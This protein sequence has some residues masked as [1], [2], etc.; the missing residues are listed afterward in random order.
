MYPV[1]IG[2]ALLA[3]VVVKLPRA[4]VLAPCDTSSA[5]SAVENLLHSLAFRQRR[6]TIAGGF[7]LGQE[8]KLWPPRRTL[9]EHSGSSSRAARTPPAKRAE[10]NAERFAV[11]QLCAAARGAGFRCAKTATSRTQFL[12]VSAVEIYLEFGV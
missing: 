6:H 10:Q 2:R 5:Q 8:I 4:L 9:S 12:G 3:L 11:S 1:L 7:P